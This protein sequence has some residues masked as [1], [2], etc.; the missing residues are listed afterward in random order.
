MAIVLR[1]DQ[2]QIDIEEIVDYLDDHSPAAADRFAKQFRERTQSLA[3]M[4]EMGRTREELGVGLRSFTMGKYVLFYR[5]IEG[6]IE[7]VR[8]AH[9][10]RDL[11]GLFEG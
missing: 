6:G 10:S 7:I 2:A 3:M 4:P 5:L 9:G 11:P 8:L 1:T